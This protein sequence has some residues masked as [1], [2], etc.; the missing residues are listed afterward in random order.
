MPALSGY[1]FP[2]FA[3]L[4]IVWGKL[5]NVGEEG[6]DIVNIFL[7]FVLKIHTSAYLNL[8]V[9]WMLFLI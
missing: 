9:E 4:D 2:T 6:G 5:R 1:S 7:L 3:N 8:S